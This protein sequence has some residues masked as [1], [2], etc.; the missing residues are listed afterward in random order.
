MTF[1]KQCILRNGNTTTVS[2]IPE[3]FAHIGKYVKLKDNGVW[4]D[5]WKVEA[6]GTRLA[7]Q[8]VENRSQDY[9]KFKTNTDI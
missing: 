1:H 8:F 3:E 2:W 9:S 5:G 4:V 6:V 7:T